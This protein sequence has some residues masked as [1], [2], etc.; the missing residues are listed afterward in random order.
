MHNKSVFDTSSDLL[1]SAQYESFFLDCKHLPLIFSS[2][3]S[4]SRDFLGFCESVGDSTTANRSLIQSKNHA[5]L[6]SDNKFF[7]YRKTFLMTELQKLVFDDQLISVYHRLYHQI[8]DW[9]L[10]STLAYAGRKYHR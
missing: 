1:V 2:F 7:K 8:L 10:S 9:M 5:E 6:T 3:L 4:E